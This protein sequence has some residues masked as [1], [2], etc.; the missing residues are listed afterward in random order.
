MGT[1]LLRNKKNNNE[2]IKK[3]ELDQQ[4]NNNNN[5]N[6]LKIKSKRSIEENISINSN[7]FISQVKNDP[8]QDY[9][10]IKFL[11]EGS[12]AKVCKV[13]HRITHD[14]RAMKIIKKSQSSSEVDDM[15]ILNEINILKKMDH[16]NI[17]KIFEFY[18]SKDSYFLVTELC[19]GGE[20][21]Q[22]IIENG[23]F[24]EE[25]ASYI[26]YQI[27]SA[28][29]YCH[30][31]KIIHR[32]LKPEN[33]LIEKREP[34]GYLRVKICDFGT[35]KIYEKGS[36]MK[37]IVGSSYYIAPEVLQKKYNEKCDL[38]SCGVILYI[39]L[40]ARPPF[41]GDN[42][43][44]IIKKVKV[45]KYNLEQ[46]PFNSLSNEC[47]DLI[48]KLLE[49]DIDKRIDA[50]TALNHPWIINNKSKEIF[51]DIKDKNMLE[52]FIENLKTYQSDSIIQETALA[53]LVHN[54][55][56]L[57]DIINAGKLFN[58]IDNSGKGKITKEEL[59]N[60]LKTKIKSETLKE[61]IDQIFLNLDSDNNGFI[62][63]EEFIRAAI[64]KEVF[65][66]DNILKFA[67]RYFDKDDS[68]EISYNEIEE[69][70]KG[71]ITKGDVEENLKKIIKEVDTNGDGLIDFGE[72]CDVMR[73]LLKNKKDDENDF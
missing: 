41:E 67:F 40:S 31:M 39:L 72:F 42:D 55:P 47:L 60:G 28:I 21:F 44:D 20:L 18:V 64:D 56:Q 8:Y 22:E 5:E 32:D 58:Q 3:E 35:S 38:W 29:N 27:F 69:V 57:D 50:E 19:S 53:Y 23:A 61:D 52:K 43:N 45:G 73:L 4:Q 15:E 62:E 65:L 36:V 51:N 24:S 13:K 14:I 54:Y 71:S 12:F 1:K 11:G 68:G 17:L 33:I 34:N 66:K 30:N 2:Q 59:Y 7:V 37:K 26:M 48:K 70:F 46:K 6:K 25:K 63:Y 9:I 16:P 49:M 10:K